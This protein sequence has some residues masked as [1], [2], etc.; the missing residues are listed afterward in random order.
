VLASPIPYPYSASYMPITSD[1]NPQVAPESTESTRLE[2]IPQPVTRSMLFR[3]ESMGV[4]G[5]LAAASLFEHGN[6][7]FWLNAEGCVELVPLAELQLDRTPEA[8]AIQQ[9]TLYNR[10]TDQQ[11]RDFLIG[12]DARTKG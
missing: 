10:Y 2:A 3:R 9:L 5:Q 1:E 11:L 8:E 12:R 6:A 4:L 7:C